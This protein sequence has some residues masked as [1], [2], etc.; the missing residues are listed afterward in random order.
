MFLR[1]TRFVDSLLVIVEFHF[2]H[3]E[4][5]INFIRYFF[6]LYYFKVIFKV[7]YLNF[8]F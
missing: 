4:L 8:D 5:I 3:L 6:I 2:N 1:A 7:N